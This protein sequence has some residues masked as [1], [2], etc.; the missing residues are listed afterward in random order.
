MDRPETGSH[1]FIV[2]VWLET[3]IG[4]KGQ[5][6]WRGRITHV[7]G[8]EYRYVTDLDE[9]KTFIVPYLEGMGVRFRTRWPVDMWLRR[10]RRRS[11][12]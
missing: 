1:S 3:S 4:E 12:R 10:K 2:K 7:P 5:A 6:R 9:I 11:D 8:G